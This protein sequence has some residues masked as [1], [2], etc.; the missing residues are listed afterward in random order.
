M[1]AV[2]LGFGLVGCKEEQRGDE[3]GRLIPADEVDSNSSKKVGQLESQ[4]ALGKLTKKKRLGTLQPSQRL[5][6]PTKEDLV[7]AAAAEVKVA[8]PVD[9]EKKKEV[10]E[11]ATDDG[12]KEERVYPGHFNLSSA[13][14][15]GID[16]DAA[17]KLAEDYARCPGKILV[18]GHTDHFGSGVRNTSLS[19]NRARAIATLLV[20]SGIPFNRLE[21]QQAGD[22][23]PIA[24][25]DTREGRAQNRRVTVECIR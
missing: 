13:N 2:G 1:F 23:M 4:P 20:E 24:P 9:V 19:D 21:L 8:K 16:Q 25:N 14:P 5:V 22:T 10:I 7:R 6:E 18:T 11:K 3:L 17:K 15:S 12:P